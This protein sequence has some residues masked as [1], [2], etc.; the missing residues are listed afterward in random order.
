[1]SPDQKVSQ[2]KPDSMAAKSRTPRAFGRNLLLE[3]DLVTEEGLG[4]ADTTTVNTKE[5]GQ[6]SGRTRTVNFCRLSYS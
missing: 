3:G 4:D 2:M 6:V 5:V 1:M